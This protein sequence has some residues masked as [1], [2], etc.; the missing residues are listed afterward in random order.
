MAAKGSIVV[1]RET[2]PDGKTTV[3]SVAWT[4]D[5]SGDLTENSFVGRGW[6][7]GMV[8]KPGTAADGYDLTLLDE[9]SLD[10]LGG[11][12]ANLSNSAGLSLAEK[13]YKIVNADF[14]HF[15][16]NGEEIT[17]T[18][19]NG[20]A[21]GTGVLDFVFVHEFPGVNYFA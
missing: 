11:G 13:Y 2:S 16:F 6:L 20:G 9:D 5:G 4:A 12:G 8:C 18:I 7:V 19:A 10:L 15:Y 14:S 17:P 3:A 1:T 21:A